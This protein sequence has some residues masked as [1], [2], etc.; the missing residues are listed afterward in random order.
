MDMIRETQRQF[1]AIEGPRAAGL[2]QVE[3]GRRTLPLSVSAADQVVLVAGP[4]FADMIFRGLSRPTLPGTEVFAEEFTLLPGG[5]FTLAMA[6]HRLG[7]DVVWAADFGNDLFSQHVLSVARAEGLNEIGFRHHHIPLRN[8]TVVFSYPGDR[9][10]TTYQDQASPPSLASL[11]RQH[12]PADAV[13]AL[14]PV[15][16]DHLGRLVLGS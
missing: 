11:L 1:D 16:P 15:R 14:A 13:V 9:A 7:H 12:Q 4:W 2:G 10:M 8:I 6:L 3:V 5:A